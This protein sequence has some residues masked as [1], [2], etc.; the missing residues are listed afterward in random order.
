MTG[1][2]LIRDVRTLRNIKEDIYKRDDY[3]LDDHRQEEFN[4]ALGHIEAAV[5]MLAKEAAMRMVEDL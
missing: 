5:Q 4:K 3:S 2:E 1:E